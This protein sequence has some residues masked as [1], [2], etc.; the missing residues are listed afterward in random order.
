MGGA[1]SITYSQLPL[2]SSSECLNDLRHSLSANWAFFV[3]K[4][5]GAVI[6]DALMTARH[7]N[8]VDRVGEA[9]FA[10]TFILVFLD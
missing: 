8:G 10:H 9:D 7:H 6:A 1:A 5:L 2:F 4:L 3:D